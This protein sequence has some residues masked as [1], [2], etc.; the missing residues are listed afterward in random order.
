MLIP[1]KYILAL[2]FILISTNSYAD[3]KKIVANQD[4]SVEHFVDFDTYKKINNEIFVWELVNYHKK[5]LPTGKPIY[6]AKNL[7]KVNCFEGKMKYVTSVY[8]GSTNGQ[9]EVISQE[10]GVGDWFYDA[11]GTTGYKELK[12]ICRY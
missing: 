5:L 6:S 4:G 9:G 2:L 3:W 8:Y 10:Q 12:T 11:P 1:M 7:L